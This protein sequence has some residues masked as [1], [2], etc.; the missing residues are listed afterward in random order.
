VILKVLAILV[1]LALT[2]LVIAATRPNTIQVQRSALIGAPPEKVFQLINDF[3]DWPRWAPQDREDPSMQRTYS[4]ADRGV[5][6]VSY[7]HGKGS[8]GRGQMTITDSVPVKEIIVTTDFI[9]PFE[10][11]NVNEFVL[12]GVGHATKVTWTMRGTNLYP[13]KVMGMFVDMDRLMGKHF[14]A[15]LENLK[16]TAER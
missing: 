11:H 1:V 15:G 4:G 8:M 13:M 9:K 10:A 14:E 12:E 7:W 6:A 3:H 2:V 16:D 5:G